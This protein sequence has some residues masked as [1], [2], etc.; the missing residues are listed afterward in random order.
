ML[1][2]QQADLSHELLGGKDQLVVDEPAGL[3]LEQRAVGVDVDRLLVL[4]CLVAT[5][6]QSGGVI[7]ISCCDRL[8]E[9]KIGRRGVHIKIWVW[10]KTT[11]L[12]AVVY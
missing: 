8:A 3:L 9:G 10:N 6:A 11:C 2:P 4:H 12:L 1:L 5:F 7:E